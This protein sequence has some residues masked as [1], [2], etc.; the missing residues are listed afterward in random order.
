MFTLDQIN[1]AHARVQSGADFPQ[2]VQDAKQLGLLSYDHY[3]VDGHDEFRGA[4][5]FMLASGPVGAPLT[6]AAQGSVEQ[7]AHAIAIHQQG[8][9][10]YTTFCQQVAAAGV[11][12][13]TVEAVSMQCIY[14]DKH[15]TVLVVEPIP[16]P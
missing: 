15:A 8:Q 4:D 3:V 5:N 1:H 7:V 9:T 14:Y 2:F 12:K 16:R 13:W 10:D 11:E 6:V